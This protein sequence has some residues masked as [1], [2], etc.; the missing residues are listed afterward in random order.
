MIGKSEEAY[1]RSDLSLILI[2]YNKLA[3]NL[4]Q[5]RITGLVGI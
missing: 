3:I 2:N 1:V 5:N 4:V